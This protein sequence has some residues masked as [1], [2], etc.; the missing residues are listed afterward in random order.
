M[1]LLFLLLAVQV[2]EQPVLRRETFSTRTRGPQVTK[3]MIPFVKKYYDCLYPPGVMTSTKTAGKTS[4]E[5]A[6]E[7][8]DACSETR[9]WAVSASM[10][11]YKP[12]RGERRPAKVFVSE[13]FQTIDQGHLTQAK[14]VD[15]LIAG[16]VQLPDDRTKP[17]NIDQPS[18]RT[19][20]K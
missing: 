13:A 19:D 1:T 12:E 14:F 15:D 2:P 16:K 5:V 11:A 9:E 7:R 18:P 8:L 4:I 3:G 17:I 10:R 20:S 6:Q